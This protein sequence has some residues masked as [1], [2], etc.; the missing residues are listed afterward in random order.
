MF[1]Y[2][3]MFSSLCFSMFI[4]SVHY[5]FLCSYVQFTMF[6]LCSYVQFTMFFLCSYVQF[7]LFFSLFIHSVGHNKQSQKNISVNFFGPITQRLAFALDGL[8]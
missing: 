2:V 8:Y 7:I 3:H 6:F 5:V 1:F 4:C